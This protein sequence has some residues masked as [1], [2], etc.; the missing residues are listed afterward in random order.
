MED[1]RLYIVSGQ[2]SNDIAAISAS[3][4]QHLSVAKFQTYMAFKTNA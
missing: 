3:K 2:N 4:S 1:L